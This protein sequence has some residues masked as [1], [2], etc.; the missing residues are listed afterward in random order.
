VI[1]KRSIRIICK[2]DNREHTNPLYISSKIL[3]FKKL[4]QY[5]NS[6]YIYRSLHGLTA[7]STSDTFRY[8]KCGINT[9]SI[10]QEELVLPLFKNSTSQRSIF[11]SGVKNYNSLPLEIRSVDNYNNFK[12]KMKMLLM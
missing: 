6:K 2:A 12:F 1:H 11:Y 8:R 5:N 7:N 9:R 4:M 3:N 10:T